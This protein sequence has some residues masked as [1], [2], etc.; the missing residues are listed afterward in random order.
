MLKK[1]IAGSIII[2]I[3][4]LLVP[5]RTNGNA[6][7]YTLKNSCVKR[8]EIL[9]NCDVLF[10]NGQGHYLNSEYSAESQYTALCADHFVDWGFENYKQGRLIDVIVIHS[11]FNAEGG[12]TFSVAGV[13][14]QFKNEGVTSHYLIDREGKI[15]KLVPDSDIAFHAGKSMLPDGR[16]NVNHCSIGIE[17]INSPNVPP[18]S[19]QYESLNL[20][21]CKLESEYPIK[22]ITGH[23]DIAPER[24]DDP[25]LFSWEK[26]TTPP[27][28]S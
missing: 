24:K 1:D 5:I 19:Y 12:D 3:I 9:N 17:L 26:V 22:I 14:D 23:S 2:I 28:K 6:K 20:L 10:I 11:T 7:Q 15:Y 16:E 25:W 8:T 13:L 21:L 18:N 27:N 4:L